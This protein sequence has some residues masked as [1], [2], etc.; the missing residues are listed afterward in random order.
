MKGGHGPAQQALV[1]EGQ[2]ILREAGIDPIFGL[3]NLIW[4]PMRVKGQHHGDTLR[5]VVDALKA[6]RADG[7]TRQDFVDKLR[8]FGDQAQ[9]RTTTNKPIA[10]KPP[11]AP[12]AFRAFKAFKA[13]PVQ[14]TASEKPT[15]QKPPPAQSV[16]SETGAKSPKPAKNAAQSKKT[17]MIAKK[18]ANPKEAT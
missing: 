5:G 2:A 13:D 10:P 3:E 12:K 11:K 4:A 6:V 1:A 18:A 17:T 16:N 7:G 8:E 15:A 9:R 14:N